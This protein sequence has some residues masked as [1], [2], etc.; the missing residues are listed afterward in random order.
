M[1]QWG[2]YDTDFYVVGDYLGDRRAD[3]A[4]YRAIG[5]IS[6]DNG[7]WFIQENGGSGRVIRPFGLTSVGNITTDR[8]ICGDYNGDGKQDIAIYRSSNS[9]FYWL[10][11][12]G[13]NFN[14]SSTIQFGQPGD[15]P[16]A[17]LRAF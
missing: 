9:T 12:P 16:V 14:S 17:G 5:T 6:G 3:F 4:V 15:I 10:N 11:S 1:A 13:F 8:P 7:T 2:E